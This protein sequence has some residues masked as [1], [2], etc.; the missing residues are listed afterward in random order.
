[1]VLR[2]TVSGLATAICVDSAFGAQDPGGGTRSSDDDLGPPPNLSSVGINI[3]S[4]DYY[5][6]AGTRCF[7]DVFK[8]S[9]PF[10]LSVPTDPLR[11]DFY[12]ASLTGTATSYVFVD[13][14][15]RYVGFC[16]GDGTF[17][18]NSG[19]G[20]VVTVDS[21]GRDYRFEFDVPDA[22]EVS[23]FIEVVITRTNA[24][25]PI[26][27]LRLVMPGFERTYRGANLFHP[28]YLAALQPFSVLRFMNAM[29][30]NN[31]TQDQWAMRPHLADQTQ[32]KGLALEYMI[33]L[34]N[35]T[36]AAPWFTIP[37]LATVDYVTQFAQ[38]VKARLRPDVDV[39][40][41]YSNETW[42]PLYQQ[43]HHCKNSGYAAGF[44]AGPTIRAAHRWHAFK[45]KEN[46]E[47][48]RAVFGTGADRIMCVNAGQMAN[49]DTER[50]TWG[51]IDQL[52]NLKYGVAPYFSTKQTKAQVLA[53]GVEG[54]LD[55]TEDRLVD[56]VV[57]YFTTMATLAE[58]HNHKLIAYEYNT[59]YLVQIYHEPDPTI[60][61]Q[62]LAILTEANRSPRMQAFFRD[63]WL[64]QFKAAGGE[65]SAAFQFSGIIDDFGDW[66]LVNDLD[67]PLNERYE[68]I[69]EFAQMTP[70]WW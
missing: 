51:G 41:E 49:L 60:R 67:D 17:T 19:G 52:P 7:T 20:E 25:D 44:D 58:S 63:V 5:D 45:T 66:G 46:F 22:D 38:T 42:N 43:F 24:A 59:A 36:G 57:P 8:A 47:I 27:N 32:G 10:G 28:D 23:N 21:R 61:A 18:V 70:R 1:M 37:H 16:D 65:M 3:P 9:S 12:P 11:T 64:P 30:T 2:A 6:L 69:R 53:G 62:L 54:V 26:R 34:C 39:Y 40:V 13:T 55:A 50:L 33:E 68:G 56:V 29:K 15:G 4:I 31:S 14:F 48:F 35:R